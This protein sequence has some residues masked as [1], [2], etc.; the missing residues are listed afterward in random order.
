MGRIGLIV[1]ILIFFTAGAPRGADVNEEL[2]GIKK[3]IREKRQLLNKNRKVETQ[4]SSELEKISE[5]L[6]EKEARLT[7]LVRC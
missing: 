3:E 7:T 4:V 6:K 5:S 1:C 2:R